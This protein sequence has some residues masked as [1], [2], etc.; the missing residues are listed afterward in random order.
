L[1]TP[2]SRTPLYQT[3]WS[4]FCS[5]WYSRLNLVQDPDGNNYAGIAGVKVSALHDTTKTLMVVDRPA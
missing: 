3:N 2:L 1:D 4:D 5:Y